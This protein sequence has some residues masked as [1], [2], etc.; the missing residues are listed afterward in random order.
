[1]TNDFASSSFIDRCCTLPYFAVLSC[2]RCKLLYPVVIP[3]KAPSPT[4]NQPK[5]VDA[6]ARLA[7]LGEKKGPTIAAQ[8]RELWPEIRSALAKGHRMRTICDCL[9]ADNLVI[10]ERTLAAY[11]ARMRKQPANPS[12]KTVSA[13]NE[14]AD[15]SERARRKI[16]APPR[17]TGQS[18]DPLEN[19]RE[20]GNKHRAFEYRPEL[21]DPKKLI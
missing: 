3:A 14:P 20:W 15:V 12:E 7:A 1:V 11:V 19:L 17:G 21:A 8:L 10:N 13:S 2:N 18:P 4:H 5:S 9:Q 6:R 16:L